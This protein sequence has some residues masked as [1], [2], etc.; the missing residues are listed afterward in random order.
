MSKEDSSNA[1]GVKPR[2]RKG[3]E[4]FIPEIEKSQ[5][6]WSLTSSGL[7]FTEIMKE[8]NVEYMKDLMLVGKYKFITEFPR[9]NSYKDAVEVRKKFEGAHYYNSE[10]V[11]PGLFEKSIFL[12]VQAEAY[13]DIHKVAAS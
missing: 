7:H 9:L 10:K 3:T 4:E 6:L 11:K 2:L 5:N 8:W 12:Y 1:G 13:D